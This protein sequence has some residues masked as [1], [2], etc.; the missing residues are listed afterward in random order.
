MG[1]Y[2]SKTEVNVGTLWRSAINL[3]AS[4]IFTI[5]KRYPK[6]STDTTKAWR[7]MPLFHY[8]DWDDFKIH[9]PQ[10]VELVF[11]EQTQGARNLKD[12]IHP[13]RA[14]YTRGRGLRNTS[15][16]NERTS[17]SGGNLPVVF[18]RGGSRF[19]CNV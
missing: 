16:D 13:E 10:D 3:G 14:I 2:G 15:G 18:K 6:Q 17:K 11:V 4:F 5:G 7:H 12:F 9:A 8:G 19:D 1:I